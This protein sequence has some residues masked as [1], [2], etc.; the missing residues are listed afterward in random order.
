MDSNRRPPPYH[1]EMSVVVVLAGGAG[2]P[3]PV[4]LPAGATVVAAD[5]GADL[6]A[7]LGLEVD[8]LVGDLDSVSPEIARCGSQ[9]S[10]SIRWRRTQR[11]SSSRSRRAA[12]SSRKRISWSVAAGGRLDHCSAACSLLAAGGLCGRPVDA[13]IGAGGG[14]RRP[15]RAHARGPIP[16]SSSRCSRARP[17]GRRRDRGSRLS[18]AR[19][20]AGAGLEPR[21][22]ERV[23]ASEAR[24]VRRAGVLLAVR[25][26]GSVTAGS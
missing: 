19:R 10:S 6:A 4:A 22:L 8:V 1:E 14:A 5:G 13:Q 12:A 18:A 15:R 25:P 26:S 7:E 2:L 16:A 9:E 3:G 21:R 23:P 20:D 11:I 17:G 24:V